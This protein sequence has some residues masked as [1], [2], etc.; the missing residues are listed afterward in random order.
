MSCYL[1]DVLLSVGYVMFC[2][3]HVS[4]TVYRGLSEPMMLWC[5]VFSLCAAI[6]ITLLILS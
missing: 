5:N 3:G 4:D 2:V 1:G 6:S